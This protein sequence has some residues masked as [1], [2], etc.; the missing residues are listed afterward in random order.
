VFCMVTE[1]IAD[2]ANAKIA[3]G[4][5]LAPYDCHDAVANTSPEPPILTE[6]LQYSSDLHT[7]TGDAYKTSITSIPTTNRHV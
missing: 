3:P 2:L 5:I 1:T 4:Y 6:L 7:G